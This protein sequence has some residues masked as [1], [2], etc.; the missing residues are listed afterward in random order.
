MAYYYKDWKFN[1]KTGRIKLIHPLGFYPPAAGAYV[2]CSFALKS[3][4][5]YFD[6]QP[7]LCTAFDD[8]LRILMFLN[9]HDT[10][11]GTLREFQL[12]SF[13]VERKSLLGDPLDRSALRIA[14]IPLRNGLWPQFKIKKIYEVFEKEVEPG[15]TR[16][17]ESFSRK[18]SGA[19]ESL[20][21]SSLLNLTFKDLYA[22]YDQNGIL[23]KIPRM[24]GR[25]FIF[26]AKIEVSRLAQ[27]P[28]PPFIQPRGDHVEN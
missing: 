12:N 1:T 19:L 14:F 11:E 9:D 15:R 8:Q 20:T 6:N 2:T 25:S 13:K 5:D 16:V 28:L 22:V 26:P 23:V 4:L 3:W 10:D 18:P 7:I 17:I 27:Y 24:N 21:E